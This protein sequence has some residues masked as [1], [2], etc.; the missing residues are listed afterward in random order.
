MEMLQ[1]PAAGVVAYVALK[2]QK[3]AR[4]ACG[5][6]ERIRAHQNRPSIDYLV[7]SSMFADK[8]SL[9]DDSAADANAAASAVAIFRA[10]RRSL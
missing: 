9:E 6:A 8:C 10:A 4:V 3:R 1:V 7:C 5:R 2:N